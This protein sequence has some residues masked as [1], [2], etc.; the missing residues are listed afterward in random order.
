VAN[1]DVVLLFH[2]LRKRFPRAAA[3]LLQDL[4]T[5]LGALAQTNP[6]A[7]EAINDRVS[8]IRECFR[9]MNVDYPPNCAAWDQ[10]THDFSRWLNG[11][12][13]VLHTAV[14]EITGWPDHKL[15][16]LKALFPRNLKAIRD[17]Y[18]LACQAVEDSEA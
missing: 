3:G 4:C 18:D 17:E 15:A 9:P 2:D 6:D 16:E 13:P 14:L 8:T 12:R 11:P 7:T 1:S 10:A 5:S